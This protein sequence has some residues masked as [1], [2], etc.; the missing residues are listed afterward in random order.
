MAV[1]DAVAPKIPVDPKADAITGPAA[2]AKA[3][4]APPVT[5][6]APTIRAVLPGF[7]LTKSTVFPANSAISSLI[8]ETNSL[9]AF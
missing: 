1:P 3:P 5:T 4:A 8:S 7:S 6:V 9:F 2:V